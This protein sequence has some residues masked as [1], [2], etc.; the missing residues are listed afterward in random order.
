MELKAMGNHEI[1]LRE[2]IDRKEKGAQDRQ[3]LEVKEIKRGCQQR[4]R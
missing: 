4:P 1:M 3:H 2:S